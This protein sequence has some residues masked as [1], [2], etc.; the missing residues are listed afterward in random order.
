MSLLSNFKCILWF[1]GISQSDWK[2]PAG[3]L[4]TSWL[5]MRH[6]CEPL[7]GNEG[8]LKTVSFKKTTEH[9]FKQVQG[10]Q[11]VPDWGGSNAETVIQRP[12]RIDLQ[13]YQN[14]SSLYFS[15]QLLHK[16]YKLF[17]KQDLSSHNLSV[18]DATELALDRPLWRLLAA[19]GAIGASRSMIVW[20][21][22]FDECLQCFNTIDW[23]TW[24]EFSAYKTSFQNHLGRWLK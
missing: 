22:E 15:K 16:C 2:M 13:I 11:W 14:F 9:M 6:L 19:S 23:V 10:R 21:L 17:I 1:T 4:H 12:S 5:N 3:Q 20:W 7:G 18:A 24:R 8:L